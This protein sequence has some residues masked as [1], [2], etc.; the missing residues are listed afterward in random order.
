M[1][2]SQWLLAPDMLAGLDDPVADL[3]V[4]RGD[5]EVDDDLDVIVRE[6]LVD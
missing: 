4:Q 3:G 6:E 5:R 2:Q 1:V